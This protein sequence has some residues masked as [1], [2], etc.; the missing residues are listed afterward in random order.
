M[1]DAPPERTASEWTPRMTAQGSPTGR[2]RDAPLAGQR[3]PHTRRRGAVP[4]GNRT[5]GSCRSHW[6]DAADDLAARDLHRR[7]PQA[8]GIR[9]GAGCCA[10]LAARERDQP[11]RAASSRRGPAVHRPGLGRCGS[12]HR[13]SGEPD[14]RP[15]SAE[16]LREPLAHALARLRAGDRD[17]LLLVSLSD[18]SYDEVA[19]A[20]AIPLGTV[21]SRLNRVR[22]KVRA[23]LRDIDPGLDSPIG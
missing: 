14:S 9:L 10:A 20:L 6:P 19:A 3:R 2:L 18:L 21:G 22:R 16:R 15:V 17:V 11:G 5:P 8:C 23:A 13:R 12:A 1:I 7:L 4:T